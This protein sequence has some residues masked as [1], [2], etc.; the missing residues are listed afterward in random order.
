VSKRIF[1]N[2]SF[3]IVHPG[4]I[5][6]LNYAR[7]LGD[8]LLVA[9]DSDARI[10]QLKGGSRPVNTES[11]RRLLLYNLKSVDTVMTFDTDQDLI[12]IIKEYQPDIMVKGSDYRNQPIIGAEYCESIVF[13][14]RIEQYSTTNKINQ[15]QHAN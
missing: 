15:I 6:L 14:D 11:E 2:G 4:H 10:R 13:F 5:H 12:N 8:Q 1:V 7:S 9:I 3:D